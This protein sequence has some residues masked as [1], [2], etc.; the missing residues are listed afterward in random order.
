MSRVL[1]SVSA[2]AMIT[3]AISSCGFTRT[4]APVSFKADHRLS[5]ESP[6]QEDEV[7]IPVRLEWKV[8]DFALRNGNRFAVFI[9][10][11]PVGPKRT[12]R[13]RLCT[14]GEKLPPQPGSERTKI[15]KDDLQRIYF[16]SKT[17][18]TL[19]CFEPRFDAP[20]R[21]R[22]THTAT[23]VLVDRNDRRIGQAATTVRFHVDEDQAKKCRG[24]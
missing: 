15:C 16:S 4:D 7:D 9:N 23:V 1:R 17:S 10:K 5:F 13:I 20:K 6:D 22:D 19:K 11:P 8:K 14:E 3:V 18:L 12:V 2:L 24:L 21:E